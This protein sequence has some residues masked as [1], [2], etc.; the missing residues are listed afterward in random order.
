MKP[1]ELTGSYKI[2][3]KYGDQQC[4]QSGEQDDRIAAN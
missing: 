4:S 3:S 2:T 1:I